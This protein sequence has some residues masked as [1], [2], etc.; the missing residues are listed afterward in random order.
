[1]RG[2]K[3]KKGGSRETHF[4]VFSPQIQEPYKANAFIS[5]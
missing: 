3:K 1:L 4:L 5:S 2:K